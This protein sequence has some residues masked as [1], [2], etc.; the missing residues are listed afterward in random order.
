MCVNTWKHGYND[1][2]S[3]ADGH[4]HILTYVLQAKAIIKMFVKKFA[5]EKLDHL[6]GKWK[7]T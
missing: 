4:I 5:T 3:D 6:P 7:N 1:H 2:N